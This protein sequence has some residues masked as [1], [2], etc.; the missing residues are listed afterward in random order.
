[1]Q[2]PDRIGIDLESPPKGFGSLRVVG[3]GCEWPEI[4]QYPVIIAALAQR[5]LE[6]RQ[7]E[8]RVWKAG[9]RV[10]EEHQ[11]VGVTG[12]LFEPQNGAIGGIQELLPRQQHRDREPLRLAVIR[13]KVGSADRLWSRGGPLPRGDVRVCQFESRVTI[14]RIA[15]DGDPIGLDGPLVILRR[16]KL[17]TLANG[18]CRRWRGSPAGRREEDQRQN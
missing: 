9:L 11:Q 13:Q 16:G 5:L 4:A 2:R 1:M 7:G 6:L 12:I 18:L 17:V 10:A 8:P 14:R 3:G 15:F